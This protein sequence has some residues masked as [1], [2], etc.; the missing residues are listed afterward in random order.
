ME[1][2][3]ADTNTRT[4]FRLLTE[5]DRI[6]RQAR[7]RF[8]LRGGWA[9]DFLIGQITR[10]HSDI[11]LVTWRRHA[12]RVQGLLENSGYQVGTITGRAAMHFLKDGQD[13]G[14]AFIKKD[15]QG[16]FVTPGRE[17]WPWPPFPLAKKVL[18]GI[19]CRTM[20]AAA[21]LEE[22]ENYEKYSG[23]PLRPKDRESIRA[24][25]ALRS[26][27]RRTPP[28]PPTRPPDA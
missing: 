16:R 21:L 2:S 4:Q 7:I 19:A 28:G 11:D 22:K 8:W 27:P 5:I 17:V 3:A 9:L 12:R 23:R 13:V 20:S 14:I 6:F 26:A 10:S 24:L 1:A 18:E 25:R 15:E